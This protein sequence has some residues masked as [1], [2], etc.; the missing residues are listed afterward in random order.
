MPNKKV[1]PMI[2]KGT[3][4]PPNFFLVS[5]NVKSPN[6]GAVKTIVAIAPL[7]KPNCNIIV[8]NKISNNTGMDNRVPINEMIII[9]TMGL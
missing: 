3:L 1:T 4:I 7:E 2:T 8:P 6:D 9:T 5:T